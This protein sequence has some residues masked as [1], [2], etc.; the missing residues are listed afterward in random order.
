[1]PR[2][3][4]RF[5][6]LAAALALAAAPVA[7][8]ID[9]THQLTANLLGTWLSNLGYIGYNVVG[10]PR[11]EFPRGSGKFALFDGGLWLGARV[12]GHVAASSSRYVV[13]APSFFAA[14]ARCRD[15]IIPESS[16][17]AL[18]SAAGDTSL[19]PR[20]C[21]GRRG[22][23]AARPPHWLRRWGCLQAPTR[24]CAGLQAGRTRQSQEAKRIPDLLISRIREK[25]KSRIKRER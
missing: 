11:L 15:A 3:R 10:G 5:A 17:G 8:D 25:R 1:M 4:I 2:L 24:F 18:P 22:G 13:S 16:L 23:T 20:S 12:S 6:P 14:S 21:G 9:I 19:C 7:A